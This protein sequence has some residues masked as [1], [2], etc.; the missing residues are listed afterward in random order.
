VI[1]LSKKVE[2]AVLF[3]GN[4]RGEFKACGVINQTGICL[5]LGLR[6]VRFIYKRGFA[7]KRDPL[8]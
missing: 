7:S 2:F 5:R 1:Y 6:P 8:I 4:Y 3:I